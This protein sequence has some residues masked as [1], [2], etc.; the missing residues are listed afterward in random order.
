MTRRFLFPALL[1]LALATEGLAAPA[2]EE[3]RSAYRRSDAVLLD[4]EGAVIHQRR[5]GFH[6]RRVDWV[7]LADVSPAVQ[8]AILQAEDRRFYRHAGVDWLAIGSAVLNGLPAGSMRGAS[9]I[10][11]QLASFLD[12][13][14][15]PRLSRK[16]LRQKWEQI[17]AARELEESWSKERIFEAYL[18]LVTFRGELQGLVSASRGLFGKEP[19]GLTQ[20]EALVLAVLARAPNASPDRV[21][22][23]AC[24]LARSL[25]WEVPCEGLAIK[26]QEALLVPRFIRPREGLAPHVAQQLLKPVEEGQGEVPATVRSTLDGRL[27]RVATEILAKHLLAV[28]AQHVQDGAVLVVDNRTGE[29]LAY[30]G[31]SGSLSTAPLVDGVRAKRQAGSTLK[32]FVYGRAFDERL[33]TTASL[34][35]DSP[36]DVAVPNGVYRPANYDNR[37]R[38]PVTARTALA[39]SLNVPAVRTAQV[40]G[41]DRVV[42]T[43]RRVGFEQVKESGEF[44]GPSIVLGSVDVSLWALVNAYRTLA[45]NGVWSDMTLTPTRHS[46]RPARKVFSPE[47]AFLV[48]SILSDREA[49]SG[50]FG[51][52]S[53]LASRFWSAVK[54]GTSKDMRDNWCVG[55]SRRYTVGVWVG[56]FSAEPMWNVSGITGA[57]PVWAGIMAWLHQTEPSEPRPAP[58]GIIGTTIVRTSGEP[59]REEWFIRGTEPS[60]FEFPGQ[61]SDHRIL[62]PVSG[63]VIALDPDMPLG[64]QRLF[65]EAQP[66]DRR[67]RWKLDG[68]DRG[69][70][71]A[72]QLWKPQ[73]GTHTLALLDEADRVLDTVQFR[74]RGN[75]KHD[76]E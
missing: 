41:L 12:K 39:S 54:T 29:V 37:F 38:G 59:A 36:M 2:F 67:L 17:R 8:Q 56:N 60:R 69:S 20:A 76:E 40:V 18:N 48:S 28:R 6:G 11:M 3:V 58:A 72:L 68:D 73:P 45:N 61:S 43:L 74:V 42:E 25:N 24:A 53:A 9:T 46:V 55:Y 19:H 14:L 44:Y 64:R 34:L 51:L 15:Q 70:A 75:G 63:S 57:A 47:A 10:S 21:A 52:E 7:G 13:E 71:G 4:R 65:F 66:R 33:L 22:Q 49:R 31:S 30:V 1:C 50:T 32:P 35:D 16:T 26:A 27:Q 5:V 62:Y 23:R